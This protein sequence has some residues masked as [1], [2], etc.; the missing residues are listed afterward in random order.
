MKSYNF[1]A[2]RVVNEAVRKSKGGYVKF[3]GP[4]GQ[5]IVVGGRLRQMMALMIQGRENGRGVRKGGS[6]DRLWNMADNASKLALSGVLIGRR[7][8]KFADENTTTGAGGVCDYFLL[9]RWVQITDLMDKRQ[10]AHLASKLPVVHTGQADPFGPFLESESIESECQI[11]LL[12]PSKKTSSGIEI[13]MRREVENTA[14]P[15]ELSAEKAA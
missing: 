3:I 4:N 1:D 2:R 6:Q 10:E 5:E 14:L 11:E 12:N 13:M 9:E 15:E 8:M 7:E